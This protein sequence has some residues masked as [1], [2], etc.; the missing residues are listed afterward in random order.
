MPGPDADGEMERRAR[1]QRSMQREAISKLREADIGA[2]AAG[3]ADRVA[4]P[5]SR[6]AI[7]IAKQFPNAFIQLHLAERIMHD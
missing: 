1:Q 7:L 5:P 4:G 3:P 2:P 6:I